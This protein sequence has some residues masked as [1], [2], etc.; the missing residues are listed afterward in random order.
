MMCGASVVTTDIESNREL[1][2][3][4]R[5]GYLVPVGDIRK[6]SEAVERLLTDREKAIEMGNRAAAD[7]RREWNWDQYIPRLVR[8]YTK[9][10][11]RRTTR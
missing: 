4:G 11:D 7:V 6:T 3:S 8:E 2:D 5:N 9:A 10:L 1:I